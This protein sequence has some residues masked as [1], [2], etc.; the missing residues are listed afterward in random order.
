MENFRK[1]NFFLVVFFLKKYS[2]SHF[3]EYKIDGE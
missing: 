3:D 1:E 2:N